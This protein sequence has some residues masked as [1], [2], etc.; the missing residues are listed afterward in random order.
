MNEKY[1]EKICTHSSSHV[2]I[3]AINLWDLQEKE[4]EEESIE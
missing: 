4:E 3:R 2:F 1:M